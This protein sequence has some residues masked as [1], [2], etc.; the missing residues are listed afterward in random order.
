MS[1]T[2]IL[3]LRRNQEPHIRVLSEPKILFHLKFSEIFEIL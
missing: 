2:E 3:Q 1:V